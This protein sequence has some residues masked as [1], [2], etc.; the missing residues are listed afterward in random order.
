MAYPHTD[1]DSRIVVLRQG[2]ET[3][4]LGNAAA[5]QSLSRWLLWMASAQ[6]EEIFE[7]HL[8]W[9]FNGGELRDR[10]RVRFVDLPKNEDSDD[11]SDDGCGDEL[12]F[13]HVPE[14]VLDKY[15][16]SAN[17]VPTGAQCPILS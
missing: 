15:W 10:P 1:N 5:L 4:V 8:S 14:A 6:A 2:R 17:E 16:N 11:A 13:Q 12:T 9:N 3:T 7:C